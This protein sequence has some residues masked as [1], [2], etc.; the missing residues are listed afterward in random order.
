MRIIAAAKEEGRG[1]RVTPAPTNDPR[2]IT[3]K[4][5]GALVNGRRGS[6]PSRTN[7]GLFYT[8]PGTA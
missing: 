8:N 1:L 5:A 7:L 4:R 2:I 6:D 3:A